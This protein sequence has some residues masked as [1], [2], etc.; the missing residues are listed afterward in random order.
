MAEREQH[1]AAS[2]GSAASVAK[3]NAA[4]RRV[5]LGWLGPVIVLVGAAVAGLAIWFMVTQRPVP[6]DVIDTFAIDPARTVVVRHEAASERG[7]LELRERG[8]LKWRALIPTYV[9]ERGRPAVAWSDQA[10]T[11]RV[12]RNGRAEV[13]AFTLDNAH[14][15]GTLRLAPDRE[16]IETHAAGPI[17]LTDHVRSYELVSGPGWQQL[18]AIDLARGQ[19][20]WDVALDPAPISAGGIDP[21]LVWLQQGPRRIEID[22]VTGQIRPSSGPLK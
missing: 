11:V 18:I 3:V 5:R 17:T 21:G 15:L 2:P 22:A 16:P 20:A 4:P 8:E 13:F 1:V 7:F 19:G 9:G 14:K 12:S 10:V 6:G